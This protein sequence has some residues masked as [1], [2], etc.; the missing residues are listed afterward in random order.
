MK[1]LI[2]DAQ[3][4]F[5][6]LIKRGYTFEL[7]KLL[8]E[9]GYNLITPEYIIE[10]VKRKE[11]KLLKYSKLNLSKLWHVFDIVLKII[12]TVSRKEYE[13]FE[14]QA[15]KFSP[16]EDFPYSALALKYKSLNIEVKIWSNDQKLKELLYNKIPVITTNEL[17]KK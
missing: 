8:N 2:V 17:K 7:I 11:E 4:I 1:V 12:S 9:K 14:E 3:V 6:S 16:S 10:E 5:A 15:K 13:Q